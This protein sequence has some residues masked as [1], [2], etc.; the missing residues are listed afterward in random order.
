[1]IESDHTLILG[2]SSKIFTIISELAI[3]NENQKK[4]RIVVLAD[5]DKVEME[6][7]IRNKV[8]NLK[9]TKVICRRGNPNDLVDLDIANPYSAKSI[10]I[11]ASED[12]NADPLT[13]KTILAIT[14]NPNRR[15]APYHI[16]AE[17]KNKKNV[18]VA[19]MV[20]KEE[21]E[22]VTTDDVIGKIMVQTSRQSGLSIVYTELLD[23]DGAEIYMNEVQES[24]GKTYG[25][26]IFLFEDSTVMGLQYADGTVKVNPPMDYIIQNGDRL[27]TITEDD[28][29]LAVSAGK[30]TLPVESAMVN[31]NSGK[32]QPERILLLGW[33]KR[34]LIIIREMDSYV[35]PGSYL[36]VVSAFD[37]DRDSI[38]EIAKTLTNIKLEFEQADTTAHTVIDSLDITAYDSIQLLCYKEEMDMQDADAQ[39]LISLLHIRRVMDETGQDIKVVSEMLDLKNRDLAE[40]TKADD[41]IVSDKL[42]SLLMSQYSENKYLSRVFDDLFNAN[43][44]EIYLKP[45]SD[46]IRPGESVDFYTVL[47]SARRKGQTA[48]GY[49]VA[50]SAH[51]HDRAYGVVINPLKSKTLFFTAQ[52]KIIVLA[53]N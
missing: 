28:D 14:N 1:M 21:V 42:I 31:F 52:D 23:F 33:N 50:A 5:M 37:T 19:K 3:A 47:E 48:I 4:P 51:D 22:I 36:K 41:F 39:T 30:A 44:S 20:G 15:E 24:V 29:T 26:S 8:E 16:V 11:L 32:I 40:V 13:I 49:R 46:Y 2:W 18:E 10:I 35:G 17:I 43:G 27:I 34:A 38:L 45:M 9:T 6:D 25:A 12:K 7:E 53:E